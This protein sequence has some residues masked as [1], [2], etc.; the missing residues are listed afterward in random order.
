MDMRN[1]WRG[2]MRRVAEARA[3]GLKPLILSV[4]RDAGLKAST[5][6]HNESGAATGEMQVPRLATLAR[7]DKANKQIEAAGETARR[8]VPLPSI[9]TSGAP[10]LMRAG[11][12]PKPTPANL[13]RFAEMPIAR[14]AINIIKDR[15]AGMQWRIEPRRGRM[16]GSQVPT[17]SPKAGD[18]G[19]APD[20]ALP[21]K[22]GART[23]H[24][25]SHISQKQGYVGHPTKNGRQGWGTQSADDLLSMEE[26]IAVLTENFEQPNPEDSFRS[27]IEQVRSCSMHCGCR[28]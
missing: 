3:A 26:R 6:E 7:D 18:K 11:V 17:L 25:S 22:E 28:I 10:T 20:P 16:M 21:P 24:P 27:M 8:T 4:S 9:L 15:V 2:A 14:R 19:G 12:M 23:G 13:R 1:G 5:T